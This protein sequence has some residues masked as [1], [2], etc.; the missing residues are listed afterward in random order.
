MWHCFRYRCVA[1]REDQVKC[2]NTGRCLW[3][4]RYFC[5]GYDDCGDMSDEP[6]NCSEWSFCLL[7]GRLSSYYC[8][9]CAKR[10]LRYINLSEGS[11][12]CNPGSRVSENPG[13]P[14]VFKPKL[15]CGQK[16]GFDRVYI[17][18]LST[19]HES[20]QKQKSKNAAENKRI[21]VQ[22]EGKY[23]LES[24]DPRESEIR[25]HLRP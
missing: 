22:L 18:G 19:A 3:A 7:N 21:K 20:V 2:N 5:N 9:H 11:R 14:P 8:L 17:S 15:V 6:D 23:S 10:K 13:N 24:T 16:P 4:T 25:A 12:E 1:C